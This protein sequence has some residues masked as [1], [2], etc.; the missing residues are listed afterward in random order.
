MYFFFAV[1]LYFL[2]A[3]ARLA[4]DYVMIFYMSPNS[5]KF[6]DSFA[7]FSCSNCVSQ[8]LILSI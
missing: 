1:T 8:S 4:D 7:T 2:L 3:S 5:S 6:S